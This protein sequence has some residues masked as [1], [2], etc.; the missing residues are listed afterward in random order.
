MEISF[1]FIIKSLVFALMLSEQWNGYVSKATKS[2]S[3]LLKYKAIVYA[4]YNL[5]NYAESPTKNVL[6]TQSCQ[7]CKYFQSPQLLKPVK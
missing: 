4:I 3:Y 6:T 1:A 2:D 5:E 7:A